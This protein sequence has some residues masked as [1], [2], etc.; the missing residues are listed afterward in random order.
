[1]MEHAEEIY[2]RPAKKW[3]QT[4]R[5]KFD[6]QNQAYHAAT[7]KH[8]EKVKGKI[9]AVHATDVQAKPK[10]KKDP[11]HGLSRAKRRRKM[12]EADDGEDFMAATAGQKALKMAKPQKESKA[13]KVKS[14]TDSLIGAQKSKPSLYAK[15]KAAEKEYKARGG[16]KGG[17][18]GKGGGGKKSLSRQV[19]RRK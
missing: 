8:L 11:L 5:Q 17:K 1:M 16:G 13:E 3:F 18:G 19:K 9:K 12:F 15:E 10:P 4:S 14:F 6:E 7:G 2:A